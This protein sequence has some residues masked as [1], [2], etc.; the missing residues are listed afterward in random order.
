MRRVVLAACFLTILAAVILRVQGVLPI[1]MRDPALA[2]RLINA[3]RVS[4]VLEVRRLLA[5]GADPNSVDE[6]GRC[7][8]FF[9]ANR[10]PRML[11]M[12]LE[13]GAA[14]NLRDNRGFSPYYMVRQMSVEQER[15]L[16]EA[17]GVE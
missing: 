13:H 12:L 1:K 17:G 3:V 11:A 15:M 5:N 8:L 6:R 9:A 4:D 14:V 2:R 7:A 16:R 10:D